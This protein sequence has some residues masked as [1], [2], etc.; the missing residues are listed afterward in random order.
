MTKK[1]LKLLFI[2]IALL[3][4]IAE[5]F[6]L[7][8]LLSITK[9]SLIPIV[10]VVYTMSKEKHHAL[11]LVL[12]VFYFLGDMFSLLNFEVAVVLTLLFFGL[13]HIVFIK[14]CFDML[15]DVRVR[16]LLF[17]ALPVIILW[18]VYYN[19]SIKDIFGDQLGNLLVPVMFYSI[20]LSI[21]T[22]VSVMSYF[23]KETKMTMYAL[24]IAITFLIGDV[25]NGINTYF[26]HSSFF[27]LASIGAQVMGYYI[28]S[29]FVVEYDFK[30]K[31]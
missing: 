29:K 20:I 14:F 23:N 12:L 5:Y 3:Y 25:I 2:A 13:G 26:S 8:L 4:I 15:Q 24:V 22:I 28:L 16:R 21:F 31:S 17:S 11:T 30:L 1:K 10:Y 6:Q 27:D 18:F 9:V 19:Y 7:K